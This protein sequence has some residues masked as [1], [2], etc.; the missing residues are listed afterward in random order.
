[1]TKFNE[2][3][4]I[5]ANSNGIVVSYGENNKHQFMRY[6]FIKKIQQEGTVKYQKIEENVLKLSPKQ[7]DIYSKVVYGFTAYSIHEI[8]VMTEEQKRNVKITFT[9]AQRIL[10]NWKQDITFTNVDNFLLALFPNSKIVKHL[11]N[12]K[13]HLDELEDETFSFKELGLKKIDI[14]NKLL[15]VGLL[16]KNF[17]QLK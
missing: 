11:A 10:R 7:Q 9:K 14:I 2:Q 15:E 1:M 17:Y 5:S 13:G 12:T 6:D 4:S 8:N 16:P 3:K